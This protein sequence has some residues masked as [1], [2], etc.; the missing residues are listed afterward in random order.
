[1]LELALSYDHILIDRGSF[2][3]IVQLFHTSSLKMS[4]SYDR[5][6]RRG[7][8]NRDGRS[9]LG[10]WVPLGLT[11]LAASMTIAAWVWSE[12]TEEDDNED[13]EKGRNGSGPEREEPPEHGHGYEQAP[14]APVSREAG[15]TGSENV[16]ASVMA[17]MSGAIRRTPSPQ[18]I[19]DQA[20]RRVV[21]GV[22]AAGAA[23]EGALS[24][25][26]EEERDDFGDHSRWS[27]EAEMRQEGPDA[28]SGAM[29]GVAGP[30]SSQAP[31]TG[32][33]ERGMAASGSAARRHTSGK[34]KSVAI[35]VAGEGSEHMSSEGGYGEEDAVCLI[36]FIFLFPTL[37][38]YIVG[39][40]PSTASHR[41]RHDAAIYFGLCS[42]SQ[43]ASASGFNTS[44]TRRFGDFIIFEY[45]PR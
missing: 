29:S 27:E 33:T 13:G 43:A 11:V 36:S 8:S 21:A 2:S 38:I 3:F 16:S 26:R 44:S 4:F 41:S 6:E 30:S 5:Y 37:K 22:A 40:A 7:R 15:P 45:R 42:E 28:P 34:R 39:A 20:S 10:Y 18:Q 32:A 24:S 17:R 35:V 19:F 23:V 14:D 9:V 31:A 12:R 1:M 25:I